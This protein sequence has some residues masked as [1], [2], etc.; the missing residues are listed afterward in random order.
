MMSIDFWGPVAAAGAVEAEGRNGLVVSAGVAPPPDRGS[1]TRTI[2]SRPASVLAG[3]ELQE[4]GLGKGRGRPEATA[5]V[6]GLAALAGVLPNHPVPA[7]E[8]PPPRPAT[9]GSGSVN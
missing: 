9:V 6:A 8:S 3:V 5:L 7:H 4:G 1:N 2:R